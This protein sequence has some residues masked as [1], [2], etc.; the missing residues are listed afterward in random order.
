MDWYLQS[1]IT[2]GEQQNSER[3]MFV[4]L[5]SVNWPKIEQSDIFSIYDFLRRSRKKNKYRWF[6]VEGFGDG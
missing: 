6:K 1:V 5:V 4:D 2:H 3:S